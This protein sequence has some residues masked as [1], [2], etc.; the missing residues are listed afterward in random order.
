[1]HGNLE[2]EK[3][4]KFR[5]VLYWGS[6]QRTSRRP[7]DC[8]KNDRVDESLKHAISIFP[9]IALLIRIIFLNAFTT[10]TVWGLDS[11][12]W[13]DEKQSWANPSHRRKSHPRNLWDLCNFRDLWDFSL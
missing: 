6:I 13:G 12:V 5:Q 10:K 2:P 9:T 4:E 11:D 8:G 7:L 3:W 1:M